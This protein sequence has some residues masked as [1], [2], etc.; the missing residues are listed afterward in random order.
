[1]KTNAFLIPV[2][3]FLFAGANCMTSSRAN[4][5]LFRAV[6]R[7]DVEMARSTLE[8]ANL[9]A[10]DR[11]GVTPLHGAVRNKDRDMVQLLLDAG[12]DPDTRDE[13]GYPPLSVV[14]DLDI[15]RMLLDAG[16]SACR[17]EL[18]QKIIVTDRSRLLLSRQESAELRQI[19]HLVQWRR[20]RCWR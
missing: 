13:N 4:R 3:L 14:V 15:A 18:L 9:E 10:R 11:F 7:G 16:A 2:I 17:V 1:M 20:R 19:I 8:M 12:A 5:K 6:D